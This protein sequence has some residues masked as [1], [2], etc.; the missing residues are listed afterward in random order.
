M[1]LLARTYRTVRAYLRKPVRVPVIFQMAGTLYMN[2]LHFD[3]LRKKVPAS[4]GL[5]L[6]SYRGVKVVSDHYCPAW[7]LPTR[8]ENALHEWRAR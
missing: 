5:N 1:K 6:A 4:A 2:Q 8:K 7:R 3:A